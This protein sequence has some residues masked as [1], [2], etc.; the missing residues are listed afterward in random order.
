MNKSLKQVLLVCVCLFA[1]TG[2]AIAD[3]LSDAKGAYDAG[4]YAKAAKLYKPLAQLG[5]AGAQTNLGLMHYQGKGVPQDYKEA[6]KWFRLA[7]KNG[8]APAQSRLGDMYLNGR[9]VLRD[10]KKAVKLFRLAA[11]NGYVPAQTRLGDMYQNGLGV[12]KNYVLAYM[13]KDIAAANAQTGELKQ[14]KQMTLQQIA[15]AHELA[16]KCTANKFKGC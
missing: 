7:A 1:L 9:G 6:V 4:D 12:P 10:Y 14:L 16:R 11:E 8:Y 13:W 15:E 2:Q 5:D 3:S